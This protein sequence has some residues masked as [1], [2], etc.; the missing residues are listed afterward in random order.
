[1]ELVGN[2]AEAG[3]TTHGFPLRILA[4]RGFVVVTPP[5]P[6]REREYWALHPDG[7]RIM[8]SSPIVLLGLVATLDALGNDWHAHPKVQ[9]PNAD[10]DAVDLDPES[11][12]ELDAHE[13]PRAREALRLFLAIE[14]HPMSANEDMIAAS[15]RYVK[16]RDEPEDT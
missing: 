13:V 8:G 7:I 2:I 3:N 10:T 14:G 12:A 15:R 11:L 1:M 16:Q 6:T 9:L 4:A 5:G